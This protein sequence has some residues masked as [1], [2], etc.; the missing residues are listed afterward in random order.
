MYSTTEDIIE[1]NTEG[2]IEGTLEGFL[3]DTT[4]YT[5]EGSRRVFAGAPLPP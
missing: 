1:A 3:G 2:I 4:R 5:T